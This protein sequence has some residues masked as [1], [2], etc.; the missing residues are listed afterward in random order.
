MSTNEKL[1]KYLLSNGFVIIAQTVSEYYGD[2]A[3]TYSNKS[4][5]IRLVSDRSVESIGV[6]SLEDSDQ[7][8]DLSIIK[9]LLMDRQYAIPESGQYEFLE[10]YF[11]HICELFS[12]KEYLSS[13][14]ALESLRNK[15]AKQMFPNS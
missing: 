10:K 15:R 7:W 11:Y 4:V 13:K 1:N 5:N 12:K 2:Y 9:I 6:S 3:Y 14:N 8:F